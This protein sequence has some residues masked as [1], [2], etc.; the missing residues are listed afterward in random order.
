MSKTIFV[1]NGRS[2][3]SLKL[4]NLGSLL[5]ITK[6]VALD[7]Y[8]CRGSLGKYY[9]I[10][11]ALNNHPMEDFE[12]FRN[13]LN[14]GTFS[15]ESYIEF[16]ETFLQLFENGTYHIRIMTDFDEWG[17]A[18]NLKNYNSC[19]VTRDD[20]KTGN[21]QLRVQHRFSQMHSV[22]E[23]YYGGYLFRFIATQPAGQL[24]PERVTYYEN[25]I[26]SGAAPIAFVLSGE[27]PGDVESA[28]F[29]LDGH[30][31]LQAYENLKQSP[32]I[33]WLTKIYPSEKDLDFTA[34][35]L[36][37][38]LKPRLLDCQYHHM[39]ENWDM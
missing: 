26:K 15:L 2:V 33:L 1:E 39:I 17:F 11:S 14:A 16:L 28:P 34:E 38:K 18:K 8:D 3:I 12:D 37:T 22:S 9:V 36:E 4:N 21:P 6:P 30:H 24:E 29:V 7:W 27:C 35:I 10:F 32:K 31:K 19:A 5:S 25:L 13:G 23:S 20:Y